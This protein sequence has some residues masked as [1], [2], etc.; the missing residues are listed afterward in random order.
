MKKGSIQSD[1]R[2]TKSSV[3]SLAVDSTGCVG[4]ADPFTWWH[5]CMQT[6]IQCPHIEV[7]WFL[8]FLLGPRI[9]S[10]GTWEPCRYQ[11]PQV[12]VCGNG[13]ETLSSFNSADRTFPDSSEDLRQLV[14]MGN[15]QS[16]RNRSDQM[17]PCACEHFIHCCL[18]VSRSFCL[19]QK[20]SAS[21][22]HKSS[23][24]WTQLS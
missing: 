3:L 21:E 24:T 13:T 6:F 12:P 22:P 14:Q 17:R 23:S 19:E 4:R 20:L 15:P 2:S 5:R 1:Q 10:T 11:T 16:I 18:L 7:L 8:R 9:E